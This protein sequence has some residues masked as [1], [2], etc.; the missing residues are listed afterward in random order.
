MQNRPIA[1]TGA[2]PGRFALVP[3]ND[4]QGRLLFDGAEA[5][6]VAGLELV[7]YFEIAAVGWLVVTDCDCPF[8]E[9]VYLHLLDGNLRPIQSHSLGGAYAPGIVEGMER[10]GPARFHLLFPSR[11]HGHM[12]LVERRMQGL[13]RKTANWLHVTADA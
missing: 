10:L 1:D 8:E 7:A 3:L 5:G 4:Q 11:D 9:L 13:F 2:D 12:I 6:T